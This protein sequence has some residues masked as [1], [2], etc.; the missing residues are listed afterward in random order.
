[1]N[2]GYAIPD[3][4]WSFT[5]QVDSTYSSILYYRTQDIHG[6]AEQLR[7]SGVAFEALPR[8]IAKMPDHELWVAFFRDSEANLVRLM[9]EA[10]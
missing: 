9:S 7:G 1:M 6:A 4:P 2:R 10:R 8:R 5:E 3:A